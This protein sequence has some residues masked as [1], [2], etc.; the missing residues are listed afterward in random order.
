VL[1]V[2]HGELVMLGGYATFFAFTYSGIDP[3][4]TMVLVFLLLMVFGFG[5]HLAVFRFV[6]R[7]GIEERIKNSLLIAF[8]LTLI[9]Q[10]LAVRAFTADER[11]L[12]T[13]YSQAAWRLGSVRLPVIR[14][15]G[16]VLAI[17][18]VTVLG[19]MLNRTRLGRAIRATAE[20]WSLAS[21]S[22]INV[23]RI[24]LIAFGVAAGL[25]GITGTMITLGFSV[26]PSIGLAWTLKALVVVVL[27]GLGSIGGTVLA[28][29]LLGLTEGL[30]SVWLGGEYREI[31]A[32]VVF[33]LVLLVRPQGL[34]GRSLG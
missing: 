16:L 5:L 10:A 29:V 15:A 6:V 11:G 12:V 27:A 32:L 21:Q 31:V 24:Y 20:D 26:S 28:G 33:L 25:A 9:L 14:A 8:G 7:L 18:A 34:F 30:S 22:G 3:L 19:L 23:S 13:S 17:V 2:A 4:L 1:N